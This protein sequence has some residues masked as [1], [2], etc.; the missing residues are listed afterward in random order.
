MIRPTLLLLLS[1]ALLAAQPRAVELYGTLGLLGGGG[2]ESSAG[3]AAAYGGA[4]TV[5]I[6]RKLALDLDVQTARFKRDF[7]PQSTYH[8][9]K[10]WLISPSLL[11]R[12]GNERLYG[13]AGGGIGAE[14]NR[15]VTIEGNFLPD[16][17]PPGWEE[18]SP[19][20]WK[21]Y[22]NFDHRTVHAR[23]GFVY[24]PLPQLAMRVD[25]HAAW[26]HVLPNLG[27][28]IGVGYRFTRGPRRESSS[29]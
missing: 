26:A 9:Q 16:Y 22:S 4:L 29:R 17:R 27:L 6:F 10:R 24:S 14:L 21:I 20:V 18:I 19:G 2:D 28:R 7:G 23:T 1:A 5:P 13:F 15:T 8:R 3:K 11:Y 25:V 12:F